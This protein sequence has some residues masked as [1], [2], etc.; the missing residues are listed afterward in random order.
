M[1]T[2]SN[3]IQDSEREV[4]SFPGQTLKKTIEHLNM[5]QVELSERSGISNN[6]IRELIKGKASLTY[7]IA[8]KLELVLG[9]P[10]RF[11][12][13]QEQHYRESLARETEKQ[14]LQSQLEW[15]KLF[16]I[17]AMSDLGWIRRTRNKIEQLQEL[18]RFFGIASSEK[19]KE[20][21]SDKQTLLHQ[22][23]FFQR[24]PE[25]VSAWLRQGER[26]A[27]K[28]EC[29]PYKTQKFKAILLEVRALTTQPPENFITE[30][31]HLCAQAG[32]AV[33]FVSELPNIQISTFTRWINPR[34]ALIQLSPHYQKNDNFWLTLFQQAGH[35]LL[36][37][38]KQ[39]FLENGLDNNQ[40]AESQ[41]FA[42]NQLIP[43]KEIIRFLST[44]EV[45]STSIRAFAQRLGIAPSIVVGQLQ[46]HQIWPDKEIYQELHASLKD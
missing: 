4:F 24:H 25:A 43:E 5:S 16:P 20:I 44:K 33:V 38:K 15:L 26:Q 6:T 28:I 39:V 45:T 31:Q 40:I 29:V 17:R 18:L 35:L 13:N 1:E 36:H 11:W 12:N 32:V 21:W 2:M 27:Q 8:L 41:E 3:P 19:W 42:A 14:R 22:S 9:I 37:G 10:A 23:P 30:I 46:H 7:E 34:K